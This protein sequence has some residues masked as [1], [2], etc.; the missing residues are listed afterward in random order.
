MNPKI[1]FT[2]D[3]STAAELITHLLGADSAFEPLLSS[4]VEIPV[5]A[6]KLHSQAVRFEA[7]LGEELIGLVAAYCNQ[8]SR[9]RAFV[10]NVSVLFKSQRQGVSNCLMTQCINYA[11]ENRFRRLALSVDQRSVPAV[12]LYKK[13]GF[14]VTG[15]NE[16]RLSMELKLEKGAE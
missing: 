10:T 4:R 12:A 15:I 6:H 11:N 9:E 5:Y 3:R 8:N 13:F 14:L 16:T 7:W 2:V 1:Q